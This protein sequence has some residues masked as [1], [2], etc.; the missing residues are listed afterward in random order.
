[1]S[2]IIP[3]VWK[4]F[5]RLE[6]PLA[7]A[8]F[9]TLLLATVICAGW[10][11]ARHD[12]AWDWTQTASNSLTHES[13]A[14]IKR[15]DAPLRITVFAAADNPL[16]LR[17]KRFLA[18][19][20]R[21]LPTLEINYV[22]PQRFPEQ[23]RDAE[24]SL[25]GQL[26]LEYRGRRETLSDI[27]ERAISAAISRLTETRTP[28]VAVIEGHGERAINSN[29]PIDLGRF[30]RE[31]KAQGYLARSLDLTRL[32]TIPDN[33]RLVI[34]STP[35]ISFF[36]NEV[37]SLTRYL[38]RGGNLLWLLDPGTLNGL[39]PLLAQLG[40]TVLPGV[41]VDAAAASVG[42]DNPAAAVITDY[43]NDA[44]GSDLTA[45]A[46]LPGCIGFEPTVAPGWTLS[47]YLA[48]SKQSWNEIGKISNRVD[49]DE[50]IGEMPG[51]IPVVLALTRT[52]PN[53]GSAAAE[54]EQRVL[55]VGDGDFLSNAFL[56]RNGNRALGLRL[57]RW[58]S[59][60][61]ALLELPPI[62]PAAVPLTLNDLQRTLI[63][64]GAL[65]GVPG[66]FFGMGL[67]VRWRRGRYR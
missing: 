5:H 19:Y 18:R 39:E 65:V 21:A 55:I 56:S 16:G 26:L 28:W 9:V 17:I 60:E 63:G 6:R 59:R 61:D 31:L 4:Q 54:R 44:L 14:I 15:L 57:L 7:D 58:L 38:D 43:P 48:T 11:A 22:D 51:P 49:R 24:V 62:P 27:S 12:R 53:D 37:E 3:Q 23:A 50:L 35:Q 8:I 2:R 25:I 41:V 34:L 33:T 45:P 10:L 29:T 32:K 1:M 66:L 64:L 30:G 52:L 20:Q 67:I 42:A 36:P 13:L 46:V 47:S 40:L